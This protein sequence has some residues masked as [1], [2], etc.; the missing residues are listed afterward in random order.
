MDR[1]PERYN[2][3][4]VTNDFKE[5]EIK[6]K[7]QFLLQENQNNNQLSNRKSIIPKEV[8]GNLTKVITR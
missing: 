2:K 3:N 7:V 6:I 1:I 8:P 5:R 4:E